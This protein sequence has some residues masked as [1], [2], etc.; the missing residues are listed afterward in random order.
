VLKDW[1]D[2]LGVVGEAFFPILLK[3]KDWEEIW[4]TLG[5]ALT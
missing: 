2:R 4:E 5:D 1:K 3:N